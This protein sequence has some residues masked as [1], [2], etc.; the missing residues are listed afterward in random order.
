MSSID[1]CTF[2]NLLPQIAATNFVESFYPALQ[3]NRST[4]S[5][6][7]I[8]PSAMQGGVTLPTILMNGNPVE[9]GAAVQEIFE[10]QMPP[11]R[12]EIQSFDCQVLNRCYLPPESG[13]SDNKSGR[14][15]TLLVLVSGVVRFGEPRED[16]PQRVFSETFVLV[17]NPDQSG[18]RG[19][20]SRRKDFLIQS[21]NFRHVT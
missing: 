17:P 4:I 6:Y 20:G 19:R 21:Q 2:S 12:Y 8:P 1:S 5:S 13:H 11:A 7:Y 3:S 15:S 16:P 9:S 18:P 10:K 14:Q